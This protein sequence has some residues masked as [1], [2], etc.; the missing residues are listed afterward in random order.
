MLSSDIKEMENFASEKTAL[1]NKY[2]GFLSSHRSEN[3]LKSVLQKT[4]LFCIILCSN[5]CGLSVFLWVLRFFLSF[6]NQKQKNDA[7]SCIFLVKQNVL[8]QHA[9]AHPVLRNTQC[10]SVS[11]GQSW[12]VQITFSKKK[13]LVFC[14]IP[15]KSD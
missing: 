13:L 8:K 6:L 4:M 12:L 11:R 2:C 9:I 7:S 3:L 10:G 5:L 1:G 14:D 15:L